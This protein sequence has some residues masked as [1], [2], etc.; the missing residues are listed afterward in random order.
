MH[1]PPAASADMAILRYEP[2]A[3]RP[4]VFLRQA[5]DKLTLRRTE[6]Y[7]SALSPCGCPVAWPSPRSRYGVSCIM[8]AGAGVLASSPSYRQ[9]RLAPN[10]LTVSPYTLFPSRKY[11]L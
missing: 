5:R 11:S 6:T 2:E 8:R 7:A 1:E 4:R 10:V 3:G 9:A